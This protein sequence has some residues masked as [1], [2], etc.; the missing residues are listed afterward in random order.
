MAAT[1]SN[2]PTLTF[3]D[4]SVVSPKDV[5]RS[6]GDYELLQEIARGGMGVIFKA[7]QVTLNRVVAI[8]MIL[9]G[10][11]ARP[12]DVQR[13]RTEAEAAAQLDHPGIVPIYEVGEHDGQHYF[14]MAF[15]DGESLARRV[16][17]GPLDPRIAAEI[18]ETVSEAV[19]YAHDRGVIHRDLKP[20]NI[21]LDKDG[22]PRVTDFGL[23]KLIESG[24][25]LTGTGQI[26]GTPSYMAPEQASGAQGQLTI[27]VDI[28]GLGA[29]LYAML[30][31]RAPFAGSS[32]L[33]TIQQVL[34]R[35]PEP[36]SRLNPRVP[37]DLE[38]I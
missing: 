25:D 22:N 2:D 1:D 37:R 30:A 14:S 15:V 11:F 19:Q 29:V 31:G 26:L 23:A 27:A 13:F 4:R 8:K 18:V 5:I 34:D 28:Y 16:A 12:E 36:P 32:V 33:E 21:L 24:S 6:F 9:A 3:Q 17:D 7:R 35:H 20:G 10:S 38:V